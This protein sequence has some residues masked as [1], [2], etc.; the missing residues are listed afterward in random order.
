MK[1]PRSLFIPVIVIITILSTSKGSLLCFI[2]SVFLYY[3]FKIQSNF[4]YLIILLLPLIF[5]LLFN[6]FIFPMFESDIENYSSVATRG[7]MLFTSMVILL[8][9]PFGVGFFGYLPA[10]Y[11]HGFGGIQLFQ[12]IY[13]EYLNFGEVLSYFRAGVVKGVSTKTFFFDW[14]IFAGFPFITMFVYINYKILNLFIEK[15]SETDAVLLIFIIISSATYV[16]IDVRYI[17]PFAYAY[18]F[19][20]YQ[21]F[22][23]RSDSN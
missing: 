4:K 19:A 2:I 6:D 12:S 9:Y 11:T 22:K 1:V 3:F 20:R 8:E 15:K 21:L 16:P 14:V 18:L 17:V 10:I 7:T 5:A 23:L 13:P